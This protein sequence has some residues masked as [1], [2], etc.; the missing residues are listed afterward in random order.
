MA[1]ISGNSQSDHFLQALQQCDRQLEV[2]LSRSPANARLLAQDPA[3][4]L[5][6]ARLEMSRDA[7]IELIHVLTALAQKLDLGLPESAG[8]A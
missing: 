6:A 1:Y 3:A 7:M 5:Q 4:A 2:W 8:T